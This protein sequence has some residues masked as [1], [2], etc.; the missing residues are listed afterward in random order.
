MLL[1]AVATQVRHKHELRESSDEF[2]DR[3]V[4]FFS[5]E[6]IDGWDIRQAMNDLQVGAP[7]CRTHLDT[8]RTQQ[9]RDPLHPPTGTVYMH[10]QRHP[11]TAPTSTAT[12]RTPTAPRQLPHQD[13]HHAQTATAPSY[14]GVLKVSSFCGALPLVGFMP[15]SKSGKMSARK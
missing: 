15:E 12:T 2:D 3:Y 14:G 7:T 10:R 9:H 5:R 13:T 4:S 11:P 1:F 8:H 6:D